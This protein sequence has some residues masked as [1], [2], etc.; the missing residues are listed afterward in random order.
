MTG[1]FAPSPT[2]DL[3]V[4]NLRTAAI[5]W[6]SARS[7]GEPFL[8]R[9]EDLD[10]Q[11]SSSTHE[12]AQL[13]DLAAIGLD[14]DGEVVRQSDRFDRYEQA[15]A[16]LDARGLVY[17]CYCT[18]RE[19]RDEIDVVGPGTSR[20]SRLVLRAHVAISPPPTGRR[21]VPTGAARHS[22]CARTTEPSPSPTVSSA[23]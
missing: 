17:E 8:V 9:M 15:I 19:I 5:A 18:R 2:G 20:S 1:R 21:I 7:Q 16:D 22:G 11:Q 13:R 10:R 6:L 23:R 14:W 3:H 12:A 4:G